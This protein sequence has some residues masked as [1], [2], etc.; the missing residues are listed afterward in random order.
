MQKCSLFKIFSKSS[1]LCISCNK[2]SKPIICY[3]NW[4]RKLSYTTIFKTSF[5]ENSNLSCCQICICIR[6]WYWEYLW[7][8]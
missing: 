6:I 2:S 5:T 3:A 8:V 7:F 4:W 1:N